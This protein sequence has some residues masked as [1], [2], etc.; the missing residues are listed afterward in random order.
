MSAVLVRKQTSKAILQSGDAEDQLQF[1]RDIFELGEKR[2]ELMREAVVE[3]WGYLKRHRLWE[4]VWS[5]EKSAIAVLQTN[6]VQDFLRQHNMMRHR[7]DNAVKAIQVKWG[8]ATRDWMYDEMGQSY[9][10]GVSSVAKTTSLEDAEELLLRVVLNRLGAGK[11]GRGSS[12]EVI[13]QDWQTIKAMSQDQKK[14]LLGTEKPSTDMIRGYDMDPAVFNLRGLFKK[15]LAVVC[16]VQDGTPTPKRRRYKLRE[17]LQVEES[18]G[19]VEMGDAEESTGNISE[20]SNESTSSD[21]DSSSE[22]ASDDGSSVEER[23]SS[24]VDQESS[25]EEDVEKPACRCV[26]ITPKILELIERKAND[27]GSIKTDME[28]VAVVRQLIEARGSDAFNTFK[29]ICYRH[30]VNISILFGLQVRKPKADDLRRQLKACWDNRDRLDA[31]RVQDLETSAWFRLSRR[32]TTENDE[33]GC[34]SKRAANETLIEPLGALQAQL[35][36]DEYAGPGSWDT[37]M[38]DGNIIADNLFEWLWSGVHDENGVLET[39]IGTLIHEEFDMYLHHQ[40]RRNGQSNRG[41]LRT[42][43]YSL[44]Q[45]LIR[46]DIVYWAL[47][48]CLR[49]DGNIRLVSYPYYAKYAMQGD[50]TEFRHIDTAV[51]KLIQ[52]GHGAN[53]IQ[54]SVSLDHEIEGHCTE[55]V[56]GFHQHIEQWWSKVVARGPKGSKGSKGSKGVAQGHVTGL[57]KI[58]WDGDDAEFGEWVPVPCRQGGARITRPEIAHGSTKSKAAGR[59]RTILPWFVGVRDDGETL[60][61]QESETWSQLAVAHITHN[62]PKLS[63]S[64]L[65]NKYAPLP[66]RFP[67]SLH[68]NLN[69][70]VS[71]ALICKSTWDDPM[72]Q[73]EANVLLGKDRVAAAAAVKAHRLDALR[74]FKQQYLHLKKVEVQK[75]AG[76][77]FFCS[78]K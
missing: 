29:D 73:L 55:I 27:P 69:S 36:V 76:D 30:L 2:G 47:Y 56:P 62:A 49:P 46:Q 54:G 52:S 23:L 20:S 8:S 5:D 12:R 25:S 15:R 22:S 66:Y 74:T 59:R 34:F 18:D 38:Q 65:A 14:D 61:N 31:F 24:M 50:E 60:D 7:K 11:K 45:Q 26:N 3:A 77:S 44:T 58:W 37:W 10:E 70:S 78:H 67:A 6:A 4:S 33:L 35:I 57:E 39:G 68:L 71:N 75:F 72:V 19:D 16:E 1:C 43:Y 53:I 64:G 17:R 9:L 51:S 28:A 42:M 13:T 40:Q 41:W 63:P 21:G 48:A 32:G